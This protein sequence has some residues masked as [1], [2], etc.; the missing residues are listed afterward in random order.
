VIGSDKEAHRIK[1]VSVYAD[2]LKAGL[3]VLGIHA[4]DSM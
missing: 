3:A 2:T 4:P 1:L